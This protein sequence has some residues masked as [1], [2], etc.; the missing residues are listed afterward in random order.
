L[1]A[2]LFKTLKK[3]QVNS[4]LFMEYGLWTWNMDYGQLINVEFI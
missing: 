3:T 4:R 1:F 2:K